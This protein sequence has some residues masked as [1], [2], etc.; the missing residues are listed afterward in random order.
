MQVTTRRRLIMTA[1]ACAIVALT[2]WSY[3]PILHYGLNY[4]DQAWVPRIL[5]SQGFYGAGTYNPVMWL[6]IAD[7]AIYHGWLGGWHVT[8]FLLHVI[9]GILV[10]VFARQMAVRAGLS[11]SSVRVTQLLAMAIFLLHPI[12]TE[13]VVYLTGRWDLAS[14]TFALLAMIASSPFLSLPACAMALI[15]KPSAIVVPLLVWWTLRY[16]VRRPSVLLILTALWACWI[17]SLY[18][19]PQLITD[20]QQGRSRCVGVEN[21]CGVIGST[22]AGVLEY[23]AYQSLTLVTAAAHVVVPYNL[24]IEPDPTHRPFSLALESLAAVL[25]LAGFAALSKSPLAWAAGWVLLSILPRFFMRTP[26]WIHDRQ[27][28]LA[29]VGVAIGVALVLASWR[30]LVVIHPSTTTI[31]DSAHA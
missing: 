11:Y 13:A 18:M 25:A 17:G 14:T 10:S 9:N 26:E 12:Q 15:I 22:T 5:S 4:E 16:Q 24:T 28:Y 7:Q 21:G 1:L 30:S 3:F 29:F 19:A 31:G 27:L 6:S 2:A 23:P 8:N 20:L